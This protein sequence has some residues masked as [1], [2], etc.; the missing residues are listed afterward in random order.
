MNKRIQELAE[1]AGAE[2]YEG[3]AG[4]P[5]SVK[6][7]EEDF[8]KFVESIVKECAR[9]IQWPGSYEETSLSIAGNQ[10]KNHFGVEE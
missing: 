9:I 2:F 5:N 7:I 10:I 4:S 8:E 3:F 6:F 1:Q